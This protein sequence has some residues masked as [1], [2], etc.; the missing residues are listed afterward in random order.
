LPKGHSI[1]KQK[2][3]VGQQHNTPITKTN[4]CKRYNPKPKKQNKKPAP[5]AQ[6]SNNTLQQLENTLT[7]TKI[8]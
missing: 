4:N 6:Q 7:Q 5:N 1:T 3:T 8:I 2:Q